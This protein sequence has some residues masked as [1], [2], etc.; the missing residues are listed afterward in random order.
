[1]AVGFQEQ[2]D[3]PLLLQKYSLLEMSSVYNH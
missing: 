2:K 3:Y 1:M